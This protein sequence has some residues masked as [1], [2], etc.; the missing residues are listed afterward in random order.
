MLIEIIDMD[1]EN[2][3]PLF[4]LVIFR[5]KAS[6]SILNSGF[7]DRLAGFAVTIYHYMPLR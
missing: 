1:K 7:R 6:L 5:R 4:F 3:L 2:V